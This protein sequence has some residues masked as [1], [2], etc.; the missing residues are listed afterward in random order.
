MIA[1]DRGVSYALDNLV[2]RVHG[3]QIFGLSMQPYFI[4]V[5]MGI[6]ASFGVMLAFS[7][8]CPEVSFFKAILVFGAVYALYELVFLK[9]KLLLMRTRSRSYL[10]DTLLFL[11]PGFILG[12][13]I[14]G[15]PLR[16]ALDML[17]L[18]FP[19]I[20]TFVRIGCF[21]GG[22][23]FGKPSPVGVRYPS[24]MFKHDHDG[25]CRAFT[26]GADPKERVLPIQLAEAFFHLNALS[27]LSA[28]LSVKKPCGDTLLLYFWSYSVCRFVLDFGRTASVRPRRG[29]LSE[30]Q[31]V[32]LCMFLV[33][34][35]LLAVLF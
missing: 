28:R 3:R 31:V 1:I 12:Y 8:Y 23:C 18:I 30:A 14:A 35:T 7:V 2:R 5:D 15:V 10:Q 21:L 33:S 34:S 25:G 16:P 29:P 11:I 27:I 17:G 6:V 24:S 20:L 4:C 13:S 19:A 32:C 26:P 9:V 22:C